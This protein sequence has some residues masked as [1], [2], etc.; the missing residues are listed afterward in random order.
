MLAR[1]LKE[2]AAQGQARRGFTLIELLLTMGMVLVLAAMAIPAAHSA[3]ASY[4]LSAAV[5]YVSG[6]IQST[7]YQAIMHGYP[8]QLDISAATAACQI[9]SEPGGTTSFAN[10][11]GAVPISGSPITVSAGNTGH[12]TMQFKANGSVVITSGQTPPMS[13][14]I[15]YNGTTKTVTVSN[16]GSVSVH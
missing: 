3:I 6:I 14:T 7:R 8:Y 15:S 11:G 2:T 9:S 13:F 12:A 5:Q 4:Q 10:V 16:Y 1:Q